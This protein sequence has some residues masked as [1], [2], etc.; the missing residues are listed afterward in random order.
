VSFGEGPR[1]PELWLFDGRDAWRAADVP[2]A[3]GLSF[4]VR[5]NSTLI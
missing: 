5:Q 2:P 3:G 1:I 4:I